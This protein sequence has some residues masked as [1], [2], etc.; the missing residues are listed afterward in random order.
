VLE[1]KGDLMGALESRR[2]SLVIFHRLVEADQQ[3]VQAQQSLVLSYLHLGDLLINAKVGNRV[4]AQ[5]N[6]RMALEVLQH[7]GGADA[8]GSVKSQELL[9]SVRQRLGAEERGAGK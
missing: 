3:N 5:Q 7:I 1:A 6:Y 9:E 2:K 4:E 8:A